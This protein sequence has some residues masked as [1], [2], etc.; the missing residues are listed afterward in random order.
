VALAAFSLRQTL[1]KADGG[2]I[3]KLVQHLKQTIAKLDGH[4]GG[5]ATLLETSGVHDRAPNDGDLG[6]IF[7]VPG[8]QSFSVAM[9]MGLWV[10]AVLGLFYLHNT[11]DPFRGFVSVNKLDEKSEPGQA[12]SEG[13]EEAPHA[14]EEP[15][16]VE[17]EPQVEEELTPGEESTE[18]EP[19]AECEATMEQE[20][21]ECKTP[22][23]DALEGAESA[24][25]PAVADSLPSAFGPPDA[26]Q[27]TESAPE[28]TYVRRGRE[29]RAH[30]MSA[31]TKKL[32]MQRG[33]T[34]QLDDA[35]VGARQLDSLDELPTVVS[36][37]GYVQASAPTQAHSWHGVAA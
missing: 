31:L 35:F 6:N 25:P 5:N 30:I 11:R 12:P 29:R 34:C 16:C 17:E 33:A 2:D 9:V 10:S 24:D 22:T 23:S 37:I 7:F 3:S 36:R 21:D 4:L 20:E 1:L 32:D 26:P 19:L 13:R 18:E 15:P 8:N 27:G 14:E 28:V